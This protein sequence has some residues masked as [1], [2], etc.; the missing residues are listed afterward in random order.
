[1]FLRKVF[2]PTVSAAI[3]FSFSKFV[4][5][6]FLIKSQWINHYAEMG[7]DFPDAPVNG[8]VWGL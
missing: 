4:R 5:N 6:E 7:L 3:W 1:M 2:L 8:M